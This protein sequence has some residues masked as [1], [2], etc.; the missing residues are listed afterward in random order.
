VTETPHVCCY[1]RQSSEEAAKRD[2]SCPAQEQRFLT[3]MKARL[4]HGEQ[5]SW[6]VAPWDE[7][8]SGGEIDRPGLQWLL[9][10]LDRFQEI[11]VYD[12]DRLVRHRTFG[13][14]IMEEL[15]KRGIVLTG[16]WGR[17]EGTPMGRFITDTR[18]RFGAFYREEI[19]E[20]TKRTRD[21][22]LREGLWSGHAPTGY[23]Y[24]FEHGE[25]SRRLLVPDPDRAPQIQGIFRK[26]AEGH[27]QKA[28]CHLLGVNEATWIWQRDNPLYIGLVYKHRENIDALAVR[29]Y[30]TLW[31][32]ANDAEVTWVYPGRHEALVDAKT[33]DAVERLRQ[34]SHRHKTSDR[35]ALSGCLRCETCG[36]SMRLRNNHG[37]PTFRCDRCRWEK[38][39]RQAEA[40]V[41]AALGLLTQSDEF[42]AA[43]EAE[44]ARPA[45]VDR[46]LLDGLLLVRCQVIRQIE[47][48]LDVMLAGDEL[49]EVMRE[50]VRTLK[51]R[52]DTLD[53][54]IGK[55]QARLASEPS[56][57]RLWRDARHLIDLAPVSTLWENAT[58]FEQRALVK[59][60][61]Q[62]ILA[63]PGECAFYPT[64]LTIGMRLDWL[65]PSG[66]E[67]TTGPKPGGAVY[68]LV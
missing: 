28:A 24:V 23:R 56:L 50:R 7:G 12:H 44:L 17:E 48:G 47:R 16:P 10:E 64:G 46:T 63:S 62:R 26:L 35:R 51:R 32:L 20:T 18:M 3:D 52:K 61:F 9:A 19:G 39:Y 57:V 8:K 15:R 53:R 40:T 34:Q 29:T 33:W 68:R 54:E 59:G 11:Y 49:E 30:D 66:E 41:L 38:S 21:F 22:R 1:I 4:E 43:V 2:L 36:G 27:S 31:S 25:H 45:D 13:P 14:Y 67:A 55:E 65:H 58:V 60:V 37:W 6:E 5:V 42:E